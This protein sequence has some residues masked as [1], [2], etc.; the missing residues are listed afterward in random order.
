MVS[1]IETKDS[2]YSMGNSVSLIRDST[3]LVSAEFFAIV[4]GNH[5][6]SAALKKKSFDQGGPVWPP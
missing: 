4:F 1:E 6:I 5:L 3:F 2:I